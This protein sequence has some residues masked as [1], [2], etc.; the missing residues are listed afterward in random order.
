MCMC[1]CVYACVRACW[2]ACVCVIDLAFDMFVSAK[3]WHSFEN[4]LISKR[5]N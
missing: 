4:F 1:V 2:R 3:H 5:T